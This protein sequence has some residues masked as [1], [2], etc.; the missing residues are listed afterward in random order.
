MLLSLPASARPCARPRRAARRCCA[1]GSAPNDDAL[2]S[3]CPL[4]A[5]TGATGF[6][7]SALVA[8]LLLAGVRVRVLTRDVS[9]ARRILLTPG[10][11]FFDEAGWST[12]IRGASAVVN[13]AGEPISARW[14]DSVKAA[15]MSSRVEATRRVVAALEACPSEQRPSVLVSTSAVGFYGTS[16]TA[17]YDESSPAGSDYLASVCRQWEAAAAPAAGLGVRLVIA[18][19]GIVLDRGGGALAKLVPAFALFAGGPPGDGR[20]YFSWIHRD[21]A[22]GILI[23]ALTTP[24]V[25]GVLNAT[26]PTPVRMTDFCAV[27][28]SCMGRPSWL[29]VPEFAVAA[30]LGEGS[31]IVLEGQ[32]VLPQATLASGYSFKRPELRGALRSIVSAPF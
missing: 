9:K 1:L 23:H 16:T 2:R 6:V 10:L 20:Q 18:R 3:A 7:G 14:S 29:P 21:D 27:L 11:E 22:V 12:G 28:G 26:A 32:C 25:T 31:K 17:T 19:M 13:L 5:V 15:I 8:R 4:V 24:E 30:L